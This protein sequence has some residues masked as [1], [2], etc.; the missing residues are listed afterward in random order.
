MTL[1]ERLWSKVSP[2]PMSGCWLWTGALSSGYASLGSGA[3]AHRVYYELTRGKIPDG[4]E[5]DHKCRVPCCVNPDHLEPVTHRENMR[6][7]NF[8][9][10]RQRFVKFRA[11]GKCK[12]G[13]VFAEVGRM[14]AKGRLGMCRVCYLISREKSRV[15]RR[16]N[17]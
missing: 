17:R 11:I 12:R 13:H 5:L 15:S 8:E 10:V 4:L 3:Y 2:E 9:K 1:E 6:R 7:G 16:Q 14:N